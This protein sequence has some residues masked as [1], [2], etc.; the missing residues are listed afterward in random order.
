[1]TMSMNSTTCV[2]YKHHQFDFLL[3]NLKNIKIEI[4]IFIK[5]KAK[6]FQDQVSHKNVRDE[7]P[8]FMKLFIKSLFLIKCKSKNSLEM[9]NG[10]KSM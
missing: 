10:L 4:K 5:I 3:A 1:M 8:V 6:R 2:I 7:F 9:F